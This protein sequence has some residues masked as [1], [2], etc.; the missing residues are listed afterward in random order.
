[1]QLSIIC[2]INYV[3]S[4]V[5]IFYQM[6][7]FYNSFQFIFQSSST[8]YSISD[9]IEA[10]HASDSE[11]DE[12]SSDDE[13][14]DEW[15]E[16]DDNYNS[17]NEESS[18]DASSDDLDSSDDEPLASIAKKKPVA[19]QTSGTKTKKKKYKFNMRRQFIP[20]SDLEFVD[21]TLEP[22]PTDD[23]PYG[24]FKRF[25]TN[26]MFEYLAI[27][28]SKYAHQKAGVTLQ[29][30]A[31]E[32]ET[33]FGL[34]FHM[35]LVNMPAVGCFWENDTRY[36]PVADVM[37]RNRFQKIASN[38]HIKDNLLVTEAEKEDKAWKIR[39]WFDYLNSNFATVSPPENQ[40]VDEIMIAFKGRSYMKQYMPKK[41]KKWG[42]KLW[43]R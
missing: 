39:P 13:L 36:P 29:A 17:T 14:D 40:C 26:D 20:P 38:L 43:A 30:S 8:K 23:T 6:F 27:E 34:Y 37:S 9:V 18:S 28:S 3:V 15:C 19:G 5:L 33:F 10:I 21:V 16:P 24:Y 11:F 22:E 12:L 35:G 2:T 32:L 7:R 1:M 4:S 25:V 31:N 41:P 42:F